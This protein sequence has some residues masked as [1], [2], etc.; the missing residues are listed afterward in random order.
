VNASQALS[1]RE[2][3]GRIDV[4]TRVTSDGSV[5]IEVADD[6][7]GIPDAQRARLAEPYFTTR[8]Q[9]GGLG[10]GLFVTR[11][12]VDAHDGRL[13]FDVP[14][15][16]GT[17]VRIELPAL[18]TSPPA[19]TVGVS[20]RVPQVTGGGPPPPEGGAPLLL[21]DDEPIVL[22]LLATV[23]ESEWDVVSAADADEALRLLGSRPF[24]RIVC[25]LM[26]PGMSG[27]E[28]AERIRE[29]DPDLRRRM[30]FLT[31][32]AVTADAQAF[33]SREDVV[34]LMKP[35]DITRLR[36][37]LRSEFPVAAEGTN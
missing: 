26:L 5:A 36:E 11:G 9:D 1:G 14:P 12:I 31:G 16:G 29:I 8:A 3:G 27:M 19:T 7:P 21:I 30:V 13:V 17:L 2:K 25:D 28:L 22:R 32:G 10:L 37:V 18:A 20:S 34:H 24:Q 6:G 35:V 4:R 33:L 23:L 15:G